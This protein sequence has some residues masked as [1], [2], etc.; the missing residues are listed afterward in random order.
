MQVIH[1][2]QTQQNSETQ[3]TTAGTEKLIYNRIQTGVI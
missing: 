2:V 1:T 3:A